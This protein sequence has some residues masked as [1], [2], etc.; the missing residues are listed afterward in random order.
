MTRAQWLLIGAVG[1][2]LAIAIYLF[3][4]CPVECR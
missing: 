3:F 1:L 4:F 2:G